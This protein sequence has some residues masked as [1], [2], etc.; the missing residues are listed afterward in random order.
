VAVANEDNV[1]MRQRWPSLDSSANGTANPRTDALVEHVERAFGRD[2]YIMGTRD[3][4]P[5]WKVGVDNR[6]E[7]AAHRA[8]R[9]VVALRLGETRRRECLGR[10]VVLGEAGAM[11]YQAGLSGPRPVSMISQLST[12]FPAEKRVKIISGHVARSPVTASVSL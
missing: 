11:A 4:R 7:R 8:Q 9:V 10:K 1:V 6:V 2:E 5:K 12:A 3:H